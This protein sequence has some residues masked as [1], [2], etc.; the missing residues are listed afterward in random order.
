MLKIGSLL[1]LPRGKLGRKVEVKS[2]DTNPETQEEQN[3]VD[4]INHLFFLNTDSS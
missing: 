4:P 3:T 1:S 2:Y